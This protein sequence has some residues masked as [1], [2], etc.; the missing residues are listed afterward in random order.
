MDMKS[1]LPK[2]VL[3]VVLIIAVS[4]VITTI[5]FS[6]FYYM[7]VNNETTPP[8]NN[9]GASELPPLPV[10]IT[11]SKDLGPILADLADGR[12]VQTNVVLL[13]PEIKSKAW[14]GLR[15]V[16][17]ETL[18]IALEEYNDQIRD[19]IFSVMRVQ[20][21]TNLR[22]SNID[23]VKLMLLERI[24]NILPTQFGIIG[25]LFTEMVVTS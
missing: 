6:V 13:Y 5:A 23:T 24:N 11:L 14:F 15:E 25:I 3:T 20:V 16:I 19:A 2:M 4:V 10:N 1:S 21:S 12:Y 17:D 8:S 7:V 18:P 22:G 9:G